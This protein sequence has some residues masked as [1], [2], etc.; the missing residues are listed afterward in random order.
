[1]MHG[2]EP[3]VPFM[4]TAAILLLAGFV[5]SAIGF[6][7]GIT[8]L[9]ML[10]LVMDARSAHVLISASGVPVLAMAAWAWRG[11]IDRTALSYALLGALI[12]MPLGLWL[13]GAMSLDSLTRMTGI[14][15]IV[16][17][18]LNSRESSQGGK[19][20][21]RTS[22]FVAGGTSGFL[23]G[24]VSIAGPPIATFAIEQ[25]WSPERYKAFVVQCLLPIAIF[26]L[27]GLWATGFV[28]HGVLLQTTW[29]APFAIA[30]IF[31]GKVAT[32]RIQPS[33]F[34]NVVSASL[35]MIACLL[36]FRG[37]PSKHHLTTYS[38]ETVNE[39]AEDSVK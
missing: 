20:T 28:T 16:M 4:L 12:F 31:L 30:G 39:I 32:R 27:A 22:S 2:L 5:Q 7:Y 38:T 26:R 10:P 14:V 3:W 6:G 11:E 17:V 21:S 15:I 13:F 23:A 25:Q 33:R 34:R 8:A 19:A 37:S 9:A 18:L 24:A 29:I 1:M 35:L 36:V